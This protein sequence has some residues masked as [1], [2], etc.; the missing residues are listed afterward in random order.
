MNKALKR[1]A[2]IMAGEEI[3]SKVGALDAEVAGVKRDVG[4]LN[5]RIG[6]LDNKLDHGLGKVFDKLDSAT[7]PTPTPWGIIIAAMVGICTVCIG[8]GGLILTLILA[9]AA[10]ANSY[11]GQSIDTAANVAQQALQSHSAMSQRVDSVKDRV[12][13]LE[14]TQT[15]TLET[16][17]RVV[18]KLD[19][20]QEQ[21][22][23]RLRG[24]SHPP[25]P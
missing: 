8:G 22:L 12:G 5:A 4:E 25:A 16:L 17:A 19:R 11:F 23:Q 3:S 14:A 21:E 2:S 13:G 9:L 10:W 7:R 15:A 6:N 18:T 1:N 24:L 20:D